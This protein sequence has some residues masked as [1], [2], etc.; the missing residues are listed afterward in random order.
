MKSA[1]ERKSEFIDRLVEILGTYGGTIK[2]RDPDKKITVYMTTRGQN[3]N[4]PIDLNLVYTV[5]FGDI[6]EYE[7]GRISL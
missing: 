5:K 6:L 7:K 2:E 4:L 1:V 3:R